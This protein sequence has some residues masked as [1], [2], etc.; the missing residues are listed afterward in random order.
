M[1]IIVFFAAFMLFRN[2]AHAC[3]PT[4]LPAL[5]RLAA[6]IQVGQ[7]RLCSG[8]R[9]NEDYVITAAHCVAKTTEHLVITENHISYRIEKPSVLIH[10]DF[11]KDIKHIN[12]IALIRIKGAG[13]SSYLKIGSLQSDCD[14]YFLGF[15]VQNFVR[16]GGKW[17]NSGQPARHLSKLKVEPMEGVYVNFQNIPLDKD[18]FQG[19]SGDGDSGSV[20]I[21]GGKMIG[22]IKGSKIVDLGGRKQK[23]LFVLPLSNSKVMG[24]I[25]KAQQETLPSQ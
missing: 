15:G 14:A 13:Q 2:Q 3:I 16:T 7:H 25:N 23:I 10:P 1:R 21:Q 18:H 20:L 19:Y 22:L 11:A 4:D 6:R 9:F 17:L 8:M 12:D 24:F 5:E